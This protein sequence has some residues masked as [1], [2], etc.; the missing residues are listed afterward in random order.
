M[1]TVSIPDGMTPFYRAYY[2]GNVTNLDL[3]ELLLEK[4]LIQMPKTIRE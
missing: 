4:A 3:V 1:S 2:A